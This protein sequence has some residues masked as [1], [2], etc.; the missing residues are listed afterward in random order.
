MF[1]VPAEDTF[2]A[3]R[4]HKTCKNLLIELEKAYLYDKFHAESRNSGQRRAQLEMCRNLV[5]TGEAR[6][7]EVLAW[8]ENKWKPQYQQEYEAPL[9]AD[10]PGDV[11]K[12]TLPQ[13]WHRG[14]G[15]YVQPEKLKIPRERQESCNRWRYVSELNAGKPVIVLAKEGGKVG[16]LVRQDRRTKFWVVRFEDGNEEEFEEEA[17]Q[18]TEATDQALQTLVSQHDTQGW[19]NFDLPPD[20]RGPEA[21]SGIL[22]DLHSRK[23]RLDAIFAG[24]MQ[25]LRAFAHK[26]AEECEAFDPEE[27]VTFIAQHK[28]KLM[29]INHKIAVGCSS[30]SYEEMYEV[31][32]GERSDSAE[33]LEDIIHAEKNGLLWDREKKSGKTGKAFNEKVD[34]H[35]FFKLMR[36]L[37]GLFQ[38]GMNYEEHM[39]GISELPGHAHDVVQDLQTRRDGILEQRKKCSDR[40]TELLKELVTLRR[41]VSDLWKKLLASSD[42]CDLLT[43]E[44]EANRHRLSKIWQEGTNVQARLEKAQQLEQTVVSE[45]QEA[46]CD[47][48]AKR[49][50]VR[51]SFRDTATRT[52][53][54]MSAH[55]PILADAI[56]ATKEFEQK[57]RAFLA[58]AS[59][60]LQ[61]QVRSLEAALEA[62]EERHR[63]SGASS[64]S[65]SACN[66]LSSELKAKKEEFEKCE[67][68]RENNAQMGELAQKLASELDRAAQH[69]E[70]CSPPAQRLEAKLSESASRGELFANDCW[71]AFGTNYWNKDQEENTQVVSAVDMEEWKQSVLHAFNVKCGHL[72]HDVAEAKA[73]AERAEAALKVMMESNGGGAMLKRNMEQSELLAMIATQVKIQVGQAREDMESKYEQLRQERDEAVRVAQELLEKG[74]VASTMELGA[75]AST[76]ATGRQSNTGDNNSEAG[77]VFI[78]EGRSGSSPTSAAAAVAAAAS[79][80]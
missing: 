6:D 65:K 32:F 36:E 3:P 38:V 78:P 59:N 51:E 11:L 60:A 22:D 76:M 66:K 40:N 43:I 79:S 77:Y 17:L 52:V 58:N 39:Q 20:V 24:D 67:R 29:Q 16:N 21:V 70:D 1:I 37:D 23:A 9:Q 35:L 4:A 53:V 64:M 12:G 49:L 27:L 61:G 50:T 47:I 68:S 34:N 30:V 10:Q 33:K 15:E 75:T 74:S 2:Q 26:V 5:S 48:E 28:D 45:S 63:Q 8:L 7:E 31:F 72:E 57:R 62:E 73:R 46:C 71:S 54:D 13:T 56:Y 14:L 69:T 55:L 41:E 44:R 19:D 25:A 18:R 80:Q 42:R